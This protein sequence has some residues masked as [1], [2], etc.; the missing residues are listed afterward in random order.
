[1]PWTLTQPSSPR[2][3]A[4]SPVVEADC[5]N[6]EALQ[7]IG[8]SDFPVAVVGVGLQL[9]GVLI[10]GNLLDIGIS[11]IWAKAVSD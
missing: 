7:Q 1:M 8:A 11:Q 6:P 4:E 3:P 9:A 5:T 10:T 2:A